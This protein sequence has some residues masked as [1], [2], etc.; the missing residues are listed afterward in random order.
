MYSHPF[1]DDLM[2]WLN[3]RL[4]LEN[5]Q[6][7]RYSRACPSNAGSIVNAMPGR[8]YYLMKTRNSIESVPHTTSSS[9]KASFTKWKPIRCKKSGEEFGLTD[10][11][12]LSQSSLWMRVTTLPGF[13][14]QA[15]WSRK[16]ESRQRDK[17][18]QTSAVPRWS[19][20]FCENLRTYPLR[21]PGTRVFSL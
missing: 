21:N 6:L 1:R 20:D 14:K 10:C 16:W 9:G 13:C 4:V 11:E 19:C 7:P 12:N 5:A 3:W 17:T 2:L 15:E 8:D 18:S